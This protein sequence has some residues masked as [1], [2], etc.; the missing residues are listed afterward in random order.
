MRK[1][2]QDEAKEIQKERREVTTA[3]VTKMKGETFQQSAK[4][5]CQGAKQ[6]ETT[7]LITFKG[8]E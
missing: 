1:L 3:K 5:K 7:H 4:H 6:A 8:R 2:L